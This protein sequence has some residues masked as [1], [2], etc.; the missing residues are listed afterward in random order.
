MN[1]E[2]L[3]SGKL[4]LKSLCAFMNQL[5]YTFCRGQF[6]GSD[7][8]GAGIVSVQTAVRIYNGEWY[9]SAKG[10]VPEFHANVLNSPFEYD[11]YIVAKAEAA[12]ILKRI[13]LQ[14]N[15]KGWIKVQSHKV[16]FTNPDY[17]EIFEGELV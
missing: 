13:K 3:D 14:S 2:I 11:A 12:K 17:Y 6:L 15:K 7:Y 5:N 16:E 1:D 4:Q 8:S 9:G 10:F